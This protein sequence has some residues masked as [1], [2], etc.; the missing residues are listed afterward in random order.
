M[1]RLRLVQTSLRSQVVGR[2]RGARGEIQGNPDFTLVGRQSHAECDAWTSLRER[3]EKVS[4][5]AALGIADTGTA[6]DSRGGWQLSF[7]SE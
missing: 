4:P 2:G 1:L 6:T 7:L 3:G 5:T